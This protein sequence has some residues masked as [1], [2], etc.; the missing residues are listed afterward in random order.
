MTY[1]V[2]VTGKAARA[3]AFFEVKSI[4]PLLAPLWR[5]SIARQ[6]CSVFLLRLRGLMGSTC[7]PSKA[8]VQQTAQIKTLRMVLPMHSKALKY[9]YNR[10][11][12]IKMV[13]CYS[14]A[15]QSPQPER[16]HA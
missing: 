16:V 10:E 5:P 11:N 1:T 14:T 8:T 13:G 6:T 7:R 3:V 9:S 15:P 2:V 12:Y 4:M